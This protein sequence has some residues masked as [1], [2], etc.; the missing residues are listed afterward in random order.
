[1]IPPKILDLIRGR[2][3]STAI[4]VVGASNNPDKTGNA[5]VKKLNASGFSVLPVNPVAPEIEGIPAFKY[6]DEL[7]DPVQIVNFVTPPEVTLK[8]LSAMDP[9][10]F[11]TIWFQEGSWDEDCLSLAQSRFEF[12]IRDNCIMVAVAL[13]P[14]M[15]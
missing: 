15:A 4:A 3:P 2:S 9:A 12:V 1:M 7:P 6:L 8:V 14:P 5:I 10:R 13:H 11:N